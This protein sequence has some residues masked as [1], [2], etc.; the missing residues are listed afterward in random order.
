MLY[1]FSGVV[2]K[3]TEMPN[4]CPPVNVI[5]WYPYYQQY[6]P[7]E[8]RYVPQDLLYIQQDPQYIY[9]GPQY[10]LQD[11]NIIKK[12]E[13]SKANVD[14]PRYPPQEVY[15]P[16]V[17]TYSTE[18][19]NMPI[20]GNWCQI[21]KNIEPVPKIGPFCPWTMLSRRWRSPSDFL[22]LLDS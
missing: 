20:F 17:Y 19:T 11:P 1:L 16:A 12:P 6:P 2:R 4:Q 7:M 14:I 5:Q 8:P 22:L 10:I 13:L 18:P 21:P 9:P 15:P 3:E